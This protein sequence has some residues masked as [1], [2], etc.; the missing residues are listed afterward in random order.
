MA[1][2]NTIIEGPPPVTQESVLRLC[3]NCGFPET[4][5][6]TELLTNPLK[7]DH[8]FKPELTAGS[9]AALQRTLLLLAGTSQLTCTIAL[10]TLHVIGPEYGVDMNIM[11]DENH[12][13]N[14]LDRAFKNKARARAENGPFTGAK[15]VTVDNTGRFNRTYLY[16]AD[17]ARNGN[18]LAQAVAQTEMLAAL[19]PLDWSQLTEADTGNGHM[20]PDLFFLQKLLTQSDEEGRTLPL[21]VGEFRDI[22]TGPKT[23]NAERL[24]IR[25]MQAQKLLAVDQE[26]QA[27][28]KP[29]LWDQLHVAL[30]NQEALVSGEAIFYTPYTELTRYWIQAYNQL[31]EQTEGV[32]TPETLLSS[33]PAEI[34][35]EA[36][37]SEHSAA[38][39]L[40]VVKRSH[41]LH[42]QNRVSDTL[43]KLIE[44]DQ[45]FFGKRRPDFTLGEESFTPLFKRIWN[46]AQGHRDGWFPR[47]EFE[48][49]EGITSRINSQQVS[50]LLELD[51]GHSRLRV[52][53]ADEH[54]RR[55]FGAL[56]NALD[57]FFA[58]YAELTETPAGQYELARLFGINFLGRAG[59]EYKTRFGPVR[60]NELGDL[61]L[62][63]KREQLIA[64]ALGH[65]LS[66]ADRYNSV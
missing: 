2:S 35:A 66:I 14:R 3:R 21:P 13:L 30:D 45:S 7:L 32:V 62:P 39:F 46:L 23:G 24:L 26:N 63:V 33:M 16:E 49:I 50:R 20:I 54:Q 43:P 11:E 38:V 28:L 1:I 41:R 42:A 58:R 55:L 59:K 34:V 53:F 18:L 15:D 29:F 37:L 12:P 65:Y 9:R 60:G 17:R 6:D 48:D 19:D 56:C 25:R 47:S 22:A 51:N 44:V 5:Q 8:E 27:R 61:G 4:G 40:D 52:G 64:T 31:H 57:T 10:E 36:Q